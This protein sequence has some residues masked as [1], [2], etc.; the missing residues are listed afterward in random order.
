MVNTFY[1]FTQILLSPQI[2]FD[3]YDKMTN[4]LL[5]RELA[6]D[7]EIK[8]INDNPPTFAEPK[9]TVDVKEN[10]PEGEFKVL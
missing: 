1:N 10:T 3:I 8:D 6:F 2:Q 4:E 9:M 5:D 7:I